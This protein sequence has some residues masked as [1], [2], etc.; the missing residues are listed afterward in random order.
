MDVDQ[1][2]EVWPGG[3]G[4]TL[5]E[6]EREFTALWLYSVLQP[7]FMENGVVVGYGIGNTTERDKELMHPM[8]ERVGIGQYQT[9]VIEHLGEP[10]SR[11]RFESD[12]GRFLELWSYGRDKPRLLFVNYAA[13]TEPSLAA[14]MVGLTD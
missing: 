2:R 5:H 8:L 14:V 6:G 11:R 12:E 10:S 13:S 4:W 7:V 9:A 3:L 1:L